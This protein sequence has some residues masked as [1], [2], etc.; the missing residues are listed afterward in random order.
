M[1][2]PQMHPVEHGGVGV[3]TRTHVCIVGMW[4]KPP[5]VIGVVHKGHGETRGLPLAG[6]TPLRLIQTASPTYPG[7][8]GDPTRNGTRTPGTASLPLRLS[9][10]LIRE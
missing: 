5:W 9:P 7:A 8:Q 1:P 10:G 6:W 3:G 2:L 4:G